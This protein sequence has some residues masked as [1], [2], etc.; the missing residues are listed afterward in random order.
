[1]LCTHRYSIFVPS[2]ASCPSW[3]ITGQ[4]PYANHFI[5]ST[6]DNP[7][8]V[9]TGSDAEDRTLMAPIV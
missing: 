2:H 8:A 4:I 3:R 1:M 7:V 9:F 5:P 6:S